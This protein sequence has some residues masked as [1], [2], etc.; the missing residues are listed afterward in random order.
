[1]LGLNLIVGRLWAPSNCETWQV[2]STFDATSLRPLLLDNFIET[3]PA[4]RVH[5][6]SVVAQRPVPVEVFWGRIHLEG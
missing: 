5:Q 3:D 1:M 2:W 4:P 6:I